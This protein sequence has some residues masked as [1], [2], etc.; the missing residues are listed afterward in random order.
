[1]PHTPSSHVLLMPNSNHLTRGISNL[2]SLITKTKLGLSSGLIAHTCE[3]AL[4]PNIQCSPYFE[5][6]AH[7]KCNDATLSVSKHRSPTHVHVARLP[8]HLSTSTIT[9][10]CSVVS[11]C[12][13][14]A[15]STR[16]RVRRF[17][18]TAS[19]PAWI[20]AT[21]RASVR[22]GFSLPPNVVA[23]A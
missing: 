10:A 14:S 4:T 21:A 11:C 1:L 22:P 12:C 2:V 7:W 19:P 6:G 13:S 18:G 3:P 16:P 5:Q 20:T 9:I 23:R 17:T 15:I 8:R